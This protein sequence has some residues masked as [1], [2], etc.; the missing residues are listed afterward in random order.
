VV[1]H[2]RFLWEWLNFEDYSPMA[3]MID[4]YEQAVLAD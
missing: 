4:N 2:I 3:V 1:F